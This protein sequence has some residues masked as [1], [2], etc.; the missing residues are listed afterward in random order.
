MSIHFL[1]CAYTLGGAREAFWVGI[2]GA[3]NLGSGA[4]A[5]R[6]PSWARYLSPTSWPLV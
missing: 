1:C 6:K 5:S 4:T 2:Y 3:F